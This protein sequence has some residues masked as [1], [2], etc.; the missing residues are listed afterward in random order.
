[1][2][3]N[4]LAF[5]RANSSSRRIEAHKFYRKVGFDNEKDQKRFIKE[6]EN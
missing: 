6:I 3:K 1:M 4:N 5:L 2:Q